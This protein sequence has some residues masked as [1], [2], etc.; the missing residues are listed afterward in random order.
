[1][2]HFLLSLQAS[3][4][5]YQAGQKNHTPNPKDQFRDKRDS[6]TFCPCLHLPKSLNHFQIKDHLLISMWGEKKKASD[7]INSIHFLCLPPP[8]TAWLRR[9]RQLTDFQG[10]ARDRAQRA[11]AQ[12]VALPHP[13]R[14]LAGNVQTGAEA[15]VKIKRETRGL[16]LPSFSHKFH[17][18]LLPPSTHIWL[19]P[20]LIYRR[21]VRYN[22]CNF[23]GVDNLSDSFHP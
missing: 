3:G 18:P 1:M 6:H 11:L 16:I 4:L 8:D 17:P 10:W 20:S 5:I 23:T 7:I 13:A 21:P 19:Y 22:K 12:A 9:T 2:I 15:G 14:G